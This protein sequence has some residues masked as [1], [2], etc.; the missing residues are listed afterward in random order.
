[1]CVSMSNEM[2]WGQ[3]PWMTLEVLRSW[4]QSK[5][6]YMLGNGCQKHGQISLWLNWQRPFKNRYIFTT[7]KVTDLGRPL[8]HKF[9][10]EFMLGGGLSA[11]LMILWNWSS[12]GRDLRDETSGKP[13]SERMRLPRGHVTWPGRRAAQERA[14][15]HRSVVWAPVW[16]R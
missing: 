13:C 4:S 3:W 5:L 10:K 1:M 6:I 8:A 15:A 7:F 14:D 2:I 16:V 11:T 12:Q 9:A